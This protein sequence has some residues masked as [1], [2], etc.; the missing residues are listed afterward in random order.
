M[1]TLLSFTQGACFYR[2]QQLFMGPKSDGAGGSYYYKP[3]IVTAKAKTRRE[4]RIARHIRIRKKVEGTP[5]RPRLCVFR[6][7]KHIYVQVIDDTKMHTLASASTM[8][9]PMCEEFDYTS[10]PTIEVAKKVGEVIAKTCLEK[11][12]TKVVYD[13]GGFFYKGRIQA[14]ADS[15]RE[16]GLEF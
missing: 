4:D 5:E 8:Q 11:G 6:S 14:L 1:A 15:A 9:K 2:Q 10:G 16:H 13:R 7:N 12:I 3:L